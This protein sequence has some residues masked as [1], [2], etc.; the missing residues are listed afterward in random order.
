MITSQRSGCHSSN[1]NSSKLLLNPHEAPPQA[2]KHL[3]KSWR[4]HSSTLAEKYEF[5]FLEQEKCAETLHNR[6]CSVFKQFCSFYDA[7]DHSTGI[8]SFENC[9]IYRSKK[10]PGLLIASGFLPPVIQ[11][12][13]LSR[14][15]HRDLSNSE[16]KTNLH[17]HYNI[18]YPTEEK[19]FF[20]ENPSSLRF[21]SKDK[22]SKKNLECGKAL[23]KKL[24]WITLGGQY[25]WSRKEYPK[26]KAPKFPT[27]ISTLIVGLF[28]NIQPQAAIVNLYSPGDTLSLHRD[29]SE[30][31]D[32]GLV[33]I[34]LGCSAY[35]I[36][37]VQDEETLETK[38]EVL[39]LHSGD[40]VYMT[41]ESRFAWHGVPLIIQDTCPDYLKDWPGEE[42]PLWKGWISKKRINLN[43]RQIW[44]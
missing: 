43:V 38:S 44:D 7:S 34:S 1:S 30:K 37:G 4:F 36:I 12:E 32:R 24:R 35:F 16:H 23:E 13:L 2:L 41:E 14:L 9:K 10:I 25:D 6:L 21:Y 17:L 28:P 29:V 40:V 22:D 5:V 11:K 8:H 26:D 33:S 18:S 19:S 15:L 39:L 27:D 20:S 31:V 42:Y 3:F